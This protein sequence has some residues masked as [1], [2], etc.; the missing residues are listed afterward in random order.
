M[1]LKASSMAFD[2]KFDLAPQDTR[3]LPEWE[4]KLQIPTLTLLHHASQGHIKT[5]V[6]RPLKVLEWAFVRMDSAATP[7]HAADYIWFPKS[8]I[9]GFIP[10]PTLLTSLVSEEFVKVDSFSAVR[11]Q[12]LT[13]D[14]A[15]GLVTTTRVNTFQAPGWKLCAFTL[16]NVSDPQDFAD[17][18]DALKLG[19]TDD[20]L[21]RVVFDVRI[22]DLSIFQADLQA[23][24]ASLRSYEF[25]SE[26]YSNGKVVE[27]LPS[28]V[29]GKLSEII[30][31][32]HVI[33]RNYE[34]LSL[35]ERER[36]RKATLDY[37]D[38]DFR[39]LCKKGSSADG[40]VEFAAEACNPTLVANAAKRGSNVTPNI[41]AMLTAAKLF[42]SPNYV[43]HN[44]PA[45]HPARGQV[46][47]LLRFMGVKTKN[48]SS[49]A[50][51]IVRP[52]KA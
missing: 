43:D 8:E 19:R 38:D 6:R 22:K 51:T 17:L 5:Y 14:P 42:W 37:L 7:L 33:W 12:N 48:A 39:S 49:S 3:S 23:F 1:T 31:A 21:Q 26:L 35:E 32:N 50:A 15:R 45:T 46:E 41:L 47:G 9:L 52:E 11:S 4:K 18:Q 29:S 27:T 13:W 24:I 16:G 20:R 10:E 44:E 30:E 25:I 2:Y 36:K 40:L 28:Y 34:N